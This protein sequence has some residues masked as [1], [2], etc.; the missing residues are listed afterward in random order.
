[1]SGLDNMLFLQHLALELLVV[2]L[3]IVLVDRSVAE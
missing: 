3:P 2:V 1:M